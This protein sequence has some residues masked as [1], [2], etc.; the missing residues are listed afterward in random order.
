QP[1]GGTVMVEKLE[2]PAL[3]TAGVRSS[4]AEYGSDLVAEMLRSFGIPY[5]ALNPGASF[6]GI[7]DSFVNFDGGGPEMVVCC[8]E[9]IAVAVANGYARATGKPMVAAVHDVVGLQHAAMAIYDAWCAKLPLIVIG[10]TGPMASENRRPGTDWLHTA[11]VQ[12]NQVRDYVKW[13]DQPASIAA[14]PESLLRA[15]RIAMTEPCGPVYVCFDTDVQENPVTS[16][17]MLPDLKRYQPPAPMAPDPASLEEAAAML[18]G[19][20][21]PVIMAGAVAR[22]AEALPPLQELAE[23][24][25]APVVATGFA[26]PSSHPLN[27]SSARQDALRDAD[28]VLALDLVD[29]AGA[30]SQTSGIKDRTEFP[31]YIKPSTKVIHIS[32]WDL[33]TG[34]WA[35]DYQRLAP[36]DIPIAA[37]TRLALP[38]LVEACRTALGRDGSGAGRISD[39]RQAIEAMQA[40]ARERREAA[41]RRNWDAR[42]ISLNR[43]NAELWEAVKGKPWTGGPGRAGWEVERLEQVGATGG[44]GGGAG[45]LGLAMGSAIGVALA[46]RGNGRFH[47]HVSG[48]GQLLYT[49][50]SLWTL[51][52]LNLP[53]LTVVNNNRIYGNDE[54]HQE[55]LA[56]IRGRN[57]EN[58]P[59]GISLDNPQT[60]FATL[61]RSFNVEG[62][63]PVE[64]PADLKP[65]LE[66]AVRIVMEEQRPILVDVVTANE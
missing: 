60:D 55:H 2:T 35:T 65:V 59:I 12:G 61:A 15:Y 19:A 45:G 30:F 14:I 11:L 66:K 54:G 56:R 48:D 43:L 34:S 40:R 42:P 16:A 9:E 1:G 3:A 38:L 33:T 21:W 5:V 24:L 17:V 10:G 51:A 23:L 49:P 26:L 20:Q 44:G 52:N 13:D 27:A 50:S 4:R 63:G 64:D 6:R 22:H 58:A 29:L 47:V 18:A 36:T 32:V 46:H 31:Q 37:D 8:H 41:S 28:V 53:I 39:R 7:H 25:A 62:L 57:A